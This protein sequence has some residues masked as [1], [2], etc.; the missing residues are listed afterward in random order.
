MRCK[1]PLSIGCAWCER[2]VWGRATARWQGPPYGGS[3]ALW[4]SFA[5]RRLGELMRQG[6]TE[7]EARRVI[8]KETGHGDNRGRITLAYCTTTQEE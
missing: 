6:L 5:R 4:R 2:A 1:W 7:R 3:H 8:A